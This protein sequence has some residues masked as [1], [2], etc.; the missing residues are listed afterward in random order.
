[1]LRIVVI[2]NNLSRWIDFL[3]EQVKTDAEITYLDTY[4]EERVCEVIEEADA[5]VTMIFTPAMGKAAKRLR[6][7]QMPGTGYDKIDPDSVPPGVVVAN[8]Y[9][10]ERGIAEWTLMIC[11]ALCRKLILADSQIRRGD[12][13]FSPVAGTVDP[14]PELGGQTMGIVGLGRIGRDVARLAAAFGMRCIGNDA[15]SLSEEERN[16]LGLEFVGGLEDLDQILREADFL[17]VAVPFLASTR[18]LI[19]S[20]ELGLMKP[21][22][23]LI[24]PASSPW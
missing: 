6:F 10:H 21:T 1:M 13:G 20:R 7:I 14:Y 12:W 19:G 2:G 18:G 16:D 23:Y 17:T 4:D 15:V 3:R 24:N 11:L 8:C 9:E 22:A 5:A